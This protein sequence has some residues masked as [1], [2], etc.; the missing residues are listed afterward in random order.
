MATTTTRNIKIEVSTKGLPDLNR[1]SKELGGLNQNVKKISGSL[2]SLSGVLNSVLGFT[3]LGV[4]I[5]QIANTI[6]S[7]GLLRDRIKILSSDAAEAERAFAGLVKVANNTGQSIEGIS[8]IYARLASVLKNSGINTENLNDL[9][10][11]LQNSFRLSGATA[12]EATS[13]TIQ[14]AQGLAAGAVR[15]QE[16]RSVLEANVV[17]GDLLAKEFNTTR[18]NL[19]KLGEAGK[20][21]ADR[22][23]RALFN[24][25]DELNKKAGELNKTFAQSIQ[26]LENEFSVAI[27]QVA[28]DLG[29]QSAFQKG[30]EFA[31]EN[32][33]TLT[34][35]LAGL[36]AP[37]I[38]S[39]IVK[40][41]AALLALL[42]GVK[43]LIAG[44][45]ITGLLLL[46]DRLGVLDSLAERFNTNK[47][48]AQKL[49]DELEKVNTQYERLSRVASGPAFRQG[50]NRNQ[51]Q[52][53]LKALQAQREVLRLQL[54][55][56]NLKDFAASQQNKDGVPFF[57]QEDPEVLKK[58]NLEESIK[59]I[60]NESSKATAKNRGETEKATDALRKLNAQYIE[61]KISATEYFNTLDSA[62]VEKASFQ[63]RKGQINLQQFNDRIANSDIRQFT[64]DVNRGKI[65]FEEYNKAINQLQLQKLKNELDAGT[66]S[67]R[68][69]NAEAAK[70]SEGFSASGAL[71]IGLTSFID[72][73]GTSTERIGNVIADSFDKAGEALAQFVQTGKR[74][75]SDFAQSILDD[76]F[77]IIIQTQVTGP[78]AQGLLGAFF[79]PA[80]AATSSFA[81][82]LGQPSA[83]AFASGGIVDSPTFFG[84]GGG[85]TGLA[86]EAGPEAILPLSRGTD[87]TLGVSA[88]VSPVTINVVNNSGAQVET[89]ETAGPGGERIIELLIENKVKSGIASGSFDKAFQTS[90]GI[91]RK[92]Q[93]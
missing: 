92:G 81:G 85:R 30:I 31:I 74:D 89:R 87:G 27:Q 11:I 82:G 22:V 14:L 93:G 68:E 34:L 79:A 69:F 32:I 37:F 25:Q 88:Q 53:Q 36:A 61:G 1:F 48:E 56:Q 23:L 5:G 76:I 47:T 10:Q 35:V 71:A 83:V 42:G 91:R 17:I 51:L 59:K 44:A 90:F 19:L 38:I 39:G 63:F 45:V 16:L 66:I 20:L 55:A 4:G 33:R 29:A 77:R 80:S 46:A 52:D 72:S 2:G 41:G 6:D 50:I 9:T 7:I 13:A 70:F 12:T 3:F 58:R 43:L 24:A 26:L 60:A 73:V 86:G 54:D 57:L 84:F 67:L 18:G 78:L 62:E 15:G 64:V 40:L 65:S 49:A 28:K 75:F 8:T 21:T